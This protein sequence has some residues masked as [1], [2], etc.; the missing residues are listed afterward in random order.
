MV[1]TSRIRKLR[2]EKGK[3]PAQGH[4]QVTDGPGIEPG[5]TGKAEPFLFSPLNSKKK[6]LNFFCIRDF[7]H[8]PCMELVIINKRKRSFPHLLCTTHDA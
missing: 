1:S 8:A 7:M 4:T 5:L 6:K 3:S 2:P